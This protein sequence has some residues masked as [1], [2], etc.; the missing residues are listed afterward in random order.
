MS[1]T[2]YDVAKRAGV[3]IGTVS[4]VINHSTQITEKTKKKVLLAIKELNYQPHTVAQSLARRKTNT[5]GCIIPFFTGYFFMELLSGIQ[6]KITEFKY[7]LILYS[8]DM[9]NKKETF[10]RRVLKERKVDGILFVS[11]EIADEFAERF[12]TQKFPIVLVDSFNPKLDSIKVD[13]VDG[14]YRAT[15]HLINLGYTDIAMI[16]AQLRSVPARLRLEGYKKALKENG[17]QFREKHFVACDFTEEADG[18]NKGAGYTAMQKLLSLEDERP[19]AVFVSSDIQ[20]IGAMQAIREHGLGIPDDV[21][22][23][24][25][26]DIEL[27]EHVG[28][29]TMRQPTYDLARLSVEQLMNRIA[30]ETGH[31]FKQRLCTELVIRESC[32]FKKAK[33][34]RA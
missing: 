10:L 2:I 12:L 9:T 15:T 5:I 25:F 3:G 8:V 33:P 28:L 30:G 34:V 29:T 14:A 21:A 23:V 11:L 26:D 7:D 17:L 16:D 6:R 1:A 19:R 32:G 27:A 13:N 4:R 24:G 31:D 18:F 20:A 22:V